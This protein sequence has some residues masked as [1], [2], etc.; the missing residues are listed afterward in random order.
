M[1]SLKVMNQLGMEVTMPYTDVRKFESKGI[2]VYGL[3]EGLQVHLVDYSNFPIIMDVIVVNI[4][5]TLGMILSREWVDAL[6]MS[7]HMDLSYTTIPSRNQDCITSHNKPNRMEHIER[8]NYVHSDYNSVDP[9][10]FQGWPT[11]PLIEE[12]NINEITWTKGKGDQNIPRNHEDNIA[13]GN[14]EVL[15]L[16][17]TYKRD[18]ALV[19]P[20]PII[21]EQERDINWG[22]YP[23]NSSVI[24]EYWDAYYST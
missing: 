7:L 19:G 8:C 1:M 13:L 14:N 12:D 6:G 16:H 24:F 5:N 3:M 22:D 15:H 11:L 20:Y 23:D 18:S 17:K 2:K 10:L 4:P 21:L 9:C